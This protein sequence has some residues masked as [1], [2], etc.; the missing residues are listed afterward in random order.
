MM[1]EPVAICMRGTLGASVIPEAVGNP[2]ESRA[3]FDRPAA[4][5]KRLL[6]RSERGSTGGS[7]AEGPACPD[8]CRRSVA[9][10]PPTGREDAP[11]GVSPPPAPARRPPP[12]R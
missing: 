12:C 8:G 5:D 4:V 6:L 1:V 7:L 11:A 10:P 2:G 9:Q 3:W